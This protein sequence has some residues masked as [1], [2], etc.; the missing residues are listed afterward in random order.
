MSNHEPSLAAFEGGTPE[1]PSEWGA[2]FL[3]GLHISNLDAD[4]HFDSF[5]DVFV[6]SMLKTYAEAMHN[7]ALHWWQPGCVCLHLCVC[8]SWCERVC[9]DLRVYI[10]MCD[11]ACRDNGVTTDASTEK[12][13]RRKAKKC[14]CRCVQPID[15][16]EYSQ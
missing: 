10:R 8:A 9:F 15:M 11:L 4:S 12:Q 2:S 5:I 7:D 1:D 3:L 6:M 14:A 13:L 16:R